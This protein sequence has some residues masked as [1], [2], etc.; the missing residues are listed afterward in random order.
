MKNNTGKFAFTIA[1]II[2]VLT[3]VGII[4]TILLPSIKSAI[5]DENVARF[6]KSH[7]A[8]HNGIKELVTSDKYYLNGDLGVKRNG[9]LVD[10]AGY[11]CQTLVDTLQAKGAICHVSEDESGI[12][13]E[14]TLDAIAS[15]V[16]A[17]CEA[18]QREDIVLANGA[19]IYII[20][21]NTT[22]GAVNEANERIFN[23]PEF[24]YSMFPSTFAGLSNVD[25][26]YKVICLDIDGINQGE[27]PFGYAVRADG[28]IVNGKRA[29]EWLEKSLRKEN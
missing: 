9:E 7:I 24:Y 23:N 21:S 26:T 28:K 14:V 15:G 8:L 12:L 6:K 20:D 18:N 16:D 3:L 25:T 2:I 22:F 13:Q 1:E 27:R 29:E 5:P 4:A 19:V 11:L 17:P 10:N